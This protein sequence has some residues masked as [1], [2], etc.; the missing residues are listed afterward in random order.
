MNKPTIT[1]LFSGA[2]GVEI[3]AIAAGFQTVEA[4]EYDPQLA[5]LHKANISGKCH[6][7]NIL[8]CNPFKFEKVDVLHASPV[9]KSFSTAN[10]NKGEKQL[11][12]DCAI[13]TAQFIEVLQP[14]TFTL[15]N[16]QAY[17]KSKAFNI[18]LEKL[19]SLGY[20]VNYQTL[21]SADFGVPQ[22]RRRLILI[23]I[24]SGFIPSLPPKEAHIGWYAAIADKLRDLPDTKLADW[25]LKALPEDLRTL[26]IR[27][28]NTKQ[29]RG[30][31][32]HLKDEP[33]MTIAASSQS[34]KAIL[35]EGT[36][37]R[38]DRDL[39]TL[40]A[41]KPCWT[42]RAMG[43]DRHWQKTNALLEN[44]RIVQL[45]IACLARLQSF[46]DNYKW[47]GRK[48]LDGKGIGNS[49]PPLMYQKILQSL[50]LTA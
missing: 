17:G 46:P 41:D 21:N 49:V 7:K 9:C 3:G 44:A 25:Q 36:G 5:E 42:L 13:K 23:A 50:E 22:S 31:G 14:P 35:I 12:I 4:I 34:P 24:K 10:A 18:I 19:Y 38:S 6:V 30:K 28:D 20:W 27:C 32:Y 11:D 26:L 39:K 15:E 43:H 37:A 48:S 1:T 40:P 29:E 47:S 45:D 2:G 33:C 16:V 8:D